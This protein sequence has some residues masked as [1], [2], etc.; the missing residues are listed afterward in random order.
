MPSFSTKVK[1]QLH[2]GKDFWFWPLLDNWCLAQY[3][4]EG[5]HPVSIREINEEQSFKFFL[6]R[7]VMGCGEP[8]G[9]AV[10]QTVGDAVVKEGLLVQGPPDHKC[11][12]WLPGLAVVHGH[13]RKDRRTGSN[14][15]EF[16]FVKSY[17]MILYKNKV[18]R[19]LWL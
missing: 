7:V 3:L 19:E 9:K 6:P 13:G 18:C 4:T 1:Y 2:E 11:L 12:G 10:D 17:K 16:L 5:R 15:N 14:R 8:T